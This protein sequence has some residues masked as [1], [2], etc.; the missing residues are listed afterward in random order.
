MSRHLRLQ[1]SAAGLLRVSSKSTRS[2]AFPLPTS[3]AMCLMAP[4]LCVARQRRSYA[5]QRVI[6]PREGA[7]APIRVNNLNPDLYK[8]DGI[9]LEVFEAVVK[10]SRGSPF[11][12]LS[13][14]EY[15]EGLQKYSAAV[16]A[17]SSPWNV[18]LS[19]SKM[20]SAI[21]QK[22]FANDDPVEDAI[23][24]PVLYEIGCILRYIPQSGNVQA[25][26]LGLWSS[27]SEMGYQPSTLSLARFLITGGVW[28]KISHL[29]KVEARFR[30]IVKAGKDP[31]ALTAE[32]ELLFAQGNYDAAIKLLERTRTLPS[33]AF[34]WKPYCLLCLG[35]AYA[36]TQRHAEAK[37]ALTAALEAGCFEARA[38][39]GQLLRSSDVEKAEQYLYTAALHGKPELFRNL[40]EMAFESEANATDDDTRKNHQLWAMEWSRLADQ[41]EPY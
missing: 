17:K 38:E 21:L 1:Q 40:S 28:G 26:C 3:L 23:P 4:P 35:K 18:K 31:N 9:T 36:K 10:T 5:M 11:K 29:T 41:K 13:A 34:E 32:G 15:Y 24:A 7:R 8:L 20:F 25:L 12:N 16:M 27:A 39:L 19:G 6:R 2:A 14:A 22:G 37:E 30:N 33:A